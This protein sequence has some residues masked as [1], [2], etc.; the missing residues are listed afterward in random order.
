MMKKPLVE[1]TIKVYAD[2]EHGV[3]VETDQKRSESKSEYYNDNIGYRGGGDPP[4]PGAKMSSPPDED[5]DRLDSSYRYDNTVTGSRTASLQDDDDR[6]GGPVMSSTVSY[7]KVSS[8]PDE[9]IDR[10]EFRYD[11]YEERDL[12]NIPPPTPSLRMQSPPDEEIER[13]DEPGG[14]STISGRRGNE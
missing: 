14:S 1:I 4:V 5:I 12:R 6:P 9:E 3:R 2:E 10:P 7:S 8:P 13:P 11:D